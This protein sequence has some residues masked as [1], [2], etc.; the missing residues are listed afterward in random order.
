MNINY[1]IYYPLTEKYISI[2]PNGKPDATGPGSELQKQETKSNAAKPP[3]WSIVEKCMEE[4]TLDLLREGK[5]HI[6]ANGEKIQRSSSATNIVTDTKKD[7]SKVKDLQK[8]TKAPTQ[9][10]KHA[11]KDGKKSNK[12]EKPARSERVSKKHEASQS[13]NAEDQDDSDGGFFE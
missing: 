7:K 5:L 12:K 3:L 10:E 13:A 1:A 9:K 4:K 6:N 11:S 2:Y 8:E